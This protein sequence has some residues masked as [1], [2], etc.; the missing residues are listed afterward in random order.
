M[1]QRRTRAA[2]VSRK[3]SPF[4]CLDFSGFKSDPAGLTAEIRASEA[5]IATQAPHSLLLDID[6]H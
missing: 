3:E 6:L 5:V 4:F 2:W 1:G